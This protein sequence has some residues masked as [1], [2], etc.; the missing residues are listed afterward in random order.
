MSLA[1]VHPDAEL[2]SDLRVSGHLHALIPRER[3]PRG[4]RDARQRRDHAGR[5]RC[6]VVRAA[7][8]VAEQ[9]VPGEAFCEGDDRGRVLGAHDQV[10]FPVPDLAVVPHALVAVGDHRHA[11]HRTTA[12]PLRIPARNPMT[13]T[14]SQHPS[15]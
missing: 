10:A 14:A 6:R 5:Y 2:V 13:A 12:A 9:G 8:Q 1:E 4:R 3:Q 7:R 11:G 15:R